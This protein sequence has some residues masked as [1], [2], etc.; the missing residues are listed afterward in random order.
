MS[1]NVTR[2]DERKYTDRAVIGRARCMS[3]DVLNGPEDAEHETRD[4]DAMGGLS[5][6]L[7]QV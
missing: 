7:R 1:R 4:V 3:I 5:S 6:L 2:S